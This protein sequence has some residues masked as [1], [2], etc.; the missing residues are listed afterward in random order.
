MARAWNDHYVTGQL[1]WDIGIPEPIEPV[2]AIHELAAT[3]L[4]GGMPFATAW[5]CVA[6]PRPTPAQPSTWR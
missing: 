1:P 2:L 3:E 6:R 5:R 4:G